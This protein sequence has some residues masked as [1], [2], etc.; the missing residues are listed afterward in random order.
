MWPA[1]NN[2]MC[3]GIGCTLIPAIIVALDVLYLFE[4]LWVYWAV[5][6]VLLGALALCIY[7]RLFD[8]NMLIIL[9]PVILNTLLLRNKIV[10][11]SDKIKK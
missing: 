7:I 6:L 1:A 2:S 3:T 10:V 5:E 4:I 11:Q 9:L 8:L